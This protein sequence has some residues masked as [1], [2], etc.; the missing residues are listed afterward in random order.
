M[1]L[2]NC[3]QIKRTNI[4][5]PLGGQRFFSTTHRDHFIPLELGEGVSIDATKL[6]KSSVPLGT[7]NN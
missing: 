4:G 5:A 2:F 7:L 6:Q 3:W 1:L